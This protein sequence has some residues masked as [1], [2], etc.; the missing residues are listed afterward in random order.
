M[1]I[2]TSAPPTHGTPGALARGFL[3]GGVIG[4]SSAA[5]VTGVVIENVPVFVTGLVVP[6]VFGLVLV[7]AGAPRRARE[8]AVVPRTALAMIES[9]RAVGGETGDIPVRFDLTVAPDDAPAFRAETTRDINLVDLPDYRPRGILVVE[10]PPDRPWRVTIVQRPTPEWEARAAEAG[11]D[12]APEESKVSRPP[13][14]CAFGAFVMVGLLLGAAAVLLSFRGDLFDQD[15]SATRRSPSAERSVSA[16]MSSSSTSSSSTS[17]TV[18]SSETGT[19]DVG[20][21]QS[22]LDKGELRRAVDSL[23][24]GKGKGKGR[25]E[26]K[27]LALTVVVRER[28]LSIVFSPP[29]TQAAHFDPDSL[30]YERFP[31]LVEEARTT[32]GVR[33][34]KTWQ[35][36]VDGLAGSPSIRVGVADAE[37][38]AS[39]EADA[40]GKVVRRT[41]AK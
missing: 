18:L 10:Y 20:P 34:P 8:A 32:L 38:V 5:L 27:H 16:G 23:T 15:T 19:V 33:S 11:I 39:L 37:G 4:A 2:S 31:A 22:L 9:L 13:E 17:T 14:G 26:N 35:I 21:D 41:P 29:G 24:K 28:Q 30:P 12:S 25:G 7:L 1:T 36:S 6:V 40:R 3:T